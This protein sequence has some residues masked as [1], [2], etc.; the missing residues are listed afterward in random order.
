MFLH[1][2]LS[3]VLLDLQVREEN[4]AHKSRN[5]TLV[6]R[7]LAYRRTAPRLQ[8]RFPAERIESL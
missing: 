3:C 1:Q 2:L 8:V 6:A 7:N 4:L 5:D